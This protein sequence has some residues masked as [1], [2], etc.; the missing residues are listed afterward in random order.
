LRA[1]N[2]DGLGACAVLVVI[3]CHH[4]DTGYKDKGRVNFET[5]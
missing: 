1:S 3:E 4:H 2:Q 5:F